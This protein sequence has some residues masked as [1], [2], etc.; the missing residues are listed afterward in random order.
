MGPGL[1]ASET[2]E[3][4]DPR[5]PGRAASLPRQHQERGRRR[6][7][8]AQAGGPVGAPPG[9]SE[10]NHIPPQ[11]PT[12][13]SWFQSR[14]RQASERQETRGGRARPR[15]R[16]RGTT[17][18]W[19]H[20]AGQRAQGRRPRSRA[21]QQSKRTGL[22]PPGAGGAHPRRRPTGAPTSG[23]GP[24]RACSVPSMVMTPSM[25]RKEQRANVHRLRSRSPAIFSRPTS[26]RVTN[27]PEGSRQAGD[28]STGAPA[29]KQP[30]SR[31]AATRGTQLPTLSKRGPW[32]SAG[33][34]HHD[35]LGHTQGPAPTSC[36]LIP[37]SSPGPTHHRTTLTGAQQC[38]LLCPP[39]PWAPVWPPA[40]PDSLHLP[41]GSFP[42]LCLLRSPTQRSEHGPQ[43]PSSHSALRTR[44]HGPWSHSPMA[45]VC[46]A[47]HSWSSEAQAGSRPPSSSRTE[48]WAPHSSP[49]GAQ[50]P[51]FLTGRNASSQ[52]HNRR[53]Q[54]CE[55]REAGGLQEGH[56]DSGIGGPVWNSGSTS[57]PHRAPHQGMRAPGAALSM[58][59]TV[60]GNPLAPHPSKQP[61]GQGRT[62]APAGQKRQSSRHRLPAPLGTTPRFPRV[63][64]PLPP[65]KLC[66][67]RS[68]RGPQITENRQLGVPVVAQQQ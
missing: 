36:P 45:G 61:L 62:S 10:Q 53:E 49:S 44:P 55:G 6:R 64:P 50:G 59:G 41:R 38:P 66:S 46:P 3:D 60:L 58:P 65:K 47:W 18:P 4:R 68:G 15:A 29:E 42:P 54:I 33:S 1:P 13:F 8:P 57:C 11:R 19:R 22:L 56:R 37:R 67:S 51:S 25:V 48:A 23:A 39:P 24:T 12:S 52:A 30:P 63:Y 7:R 5:A 21:E 35:P 32:P 2:S 27:L 43:P 9:A 20:R 40:A 16:L 17:A 34:S 26:G 28:G 14:L 31:P